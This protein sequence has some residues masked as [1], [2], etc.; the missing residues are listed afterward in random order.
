MDLRA[1]A[2][3]QVD[4]AFTVPARVPQ[5]LPPL[6]ISF[7]LLNDVSIRNRAARQLAVLA[8]IS[9]LGNDARIASW[10]LGSDP[11]LRLESVS[12]WRKHQTLSTATSAAGSVCA[13]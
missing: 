13:G 10:P 5:I 1:E 8:N 11:S 3:E 4:S 2:N 12:P 9:G 6:A 7:F